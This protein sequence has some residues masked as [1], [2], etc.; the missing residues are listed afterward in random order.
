MAGRPREFAERISLGLD[1][2]LAQR[3]RKAATEDRQD[4]L[5]HFTRIIIVEGLLSR[6]GQRLLGKWPYGPGHKQ[7]YR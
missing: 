2:L 4:D 7:S 1:A 3:L 6:E 5:G